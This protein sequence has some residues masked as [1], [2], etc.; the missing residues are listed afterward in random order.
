MHFLIPIIYTGMVV[1]LL[2]DC[3]M[4][5]REALWYMVLLIPMWGPG[6]YIYRFKWH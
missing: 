5:R 2:H 4:G 3:Y 6:L 1:Y